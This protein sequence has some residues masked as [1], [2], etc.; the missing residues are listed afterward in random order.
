M[1]TTNTIE[2]QTFLPQIM[3]A[4]Q[5]AKYL[6]VSPYSVVIWAE[7]GKLPGFKTPGGKMWRFRTDEID[8][9]TKEQQELEKLKRVPFAKKFG[10]LRKMI[11]E[12]FERAG[13]T[14][15]DI[16]GL[17]AQVRAERRSTRA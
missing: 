8:N 17:I 6:G 15:K 11:R 5:A 4:K 1:A 9:W 12:G 13:Y 7:E 3:N 14:K 10:M 2:R 16:P